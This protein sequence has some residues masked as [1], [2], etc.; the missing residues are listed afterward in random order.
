MSTA[1]PAPSVPSAG[2]RAF[3]AADADGGVSI[4]LALPEAADRRSCLL[5]RRHAKQAQD[6][7]RLPLAELPGGRLRAELPVGTALREGRWDVYLVLDDEEP[8]RVLPGMN[9]LR[10]LLDREAHKVEGKLRV[11]IPYPAK[12]GHLA[13]RAWQRGPHAEA[14]EL[15]IGEGRLTLQGR[16][17][18]AEFGEEADLLADLRGSAE[19]PV[20]VEVKV[21]GDEFTATVPYRKLGPGLWDLRLRPSGAQGPRVRVGRLLDD[22]AD[23]KPVFRYPSSRVTGEYGPVEAEP[24][25]T[26]DNDLSVKV[27]ACE[28]E[29]A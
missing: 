18:G 9:D 20:T 27:Q 4:E 28:E 29:T 11:R 23:K 6:E 22:V 17:L 24:Y 21:S 5:L 16:L 3:C 7:V 8:V 13:V 19:P 15:H 26:V 10:A 14:G 12:E 1:S 25:Y 2:P